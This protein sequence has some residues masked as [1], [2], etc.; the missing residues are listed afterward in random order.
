MLLSTA[1]IFLISGCARN[2][3]LSNTP[4]ID[5]NLP[6]VEGIKTIT[7]MTAVGFEWTP[8][9]DEQIEGYYIYR[10]GPNESGFSP[11]VKIEDRYASHYVDS[12][13]I[14]GTIYNYKMS[15][16]TKNN[17]ESRPSQIHTVQTKKRL[18]SVP[19][20]QAIVGLPHRVKLLWRPHP[21]EQVV[22]YIIERN[23]L[24]KEEWE[25]IAQVDGRLNAE[26]IDANLKENHLY[27]YRV[28]VKTH[29]GVLSNPSQIVEARTKPLPKRIENVRATTNLPKKIIVTWDPT[30]QEDFSH[31]R[32]YRAPTSL[33][34][35]TYLAKTKEPRFEDLINSNGADRYYK[36][37]VVDKDGLESLKQTTPTLGATLD[38]PLPPAMTQVSLQGRT[39]VVTWESV[40]DRAVKYNVIK[41]GEGKT[42]VIQGITSK[43]F[44]DRALKLGENYT[45]EIVAIDKYGLESKPS[46]KVLV[47]IPQE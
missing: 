33:L 14:P 19:F 31:Y 41:K 43:R 27:R 9:Y 25:R 38:I 35:Y 29:D 3:Q 13:L 4:L 30:D 47:K 45:Y 10:Q 46:Q 26:Y 7:D 12:G 22:S 8:H 28:I 17:T 20:L 44:E 16:Y 42:Q 11:I 5:Q 24:D 21:N 32:V 2:P 1:L 36:V 37:T 40:D 39:A 6:T 34:F 18:E 15:T 23:E